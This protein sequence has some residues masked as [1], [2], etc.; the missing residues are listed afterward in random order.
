MRCL[1]ILLVLLPAA[2]AQDT[3]GQKMDH[4]PGAVLLVVPMRYGTPVLL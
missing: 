4:A 2:L 1:A 3:T